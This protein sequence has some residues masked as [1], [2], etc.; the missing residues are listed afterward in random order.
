MNKMEN[1]GAALM[2]KND[3][4]YNLRDLFR[5]Y[6]ERTFTFKMCVDT[7]SDADYFYKANA[8]ELA[9]KS[10]NEAHKYRW[11]DLRKDPNDLPEAGIRVLIF[12]GEFYEIWELWNLG[13]NCIAW[14]DDESFDHPVGDAYAWRYIEPFEEK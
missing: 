3:I 8:V 9:I 7:E 10:L 5:F 1:K 14:E 6:A 12:D 13:E 2:T 11:H 4:I